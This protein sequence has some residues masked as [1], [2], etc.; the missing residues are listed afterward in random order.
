MSLPLDDAQV[1]RHTFRMMADQTAIC[2]EELLNQG[3]NGSLLEQM[4]IAWW[5][6]LITTSLTP[7]LSEIMQALLKPPEEE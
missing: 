3:F 1:S 2:R 5:Q 6:S 7:N 4:L